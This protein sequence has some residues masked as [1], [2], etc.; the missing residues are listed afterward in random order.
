MSQYKNKGKNSSKKMI[1]EIYTPLHIGSGEELKNNHDFIFKNSRH[2]VVNIKQTLD[3]IQADDPKLNDYYKTT[4]LEDLVKIAGQEYGYSLPSF[5]KNPLL[6]KSSASLSSSK[7]LRSGKRDKPFSIGSDRSADRGNLGIETIREHLKDVF[8]RPFIPGSS[9]KGAIRTAL[10][11][12]SLYQDKQYRA[13]IKNSLNNFLKKTQ[14][15]KFKKNLENDIFGENPQEDIMRSLHISDGY[16]ETDHLRLGDVRTANVCGD[17]IQ[18]KHLSRR[19]NH[20]DWRMAKGTFIEVLGEGAKAE[21]VFSWDEFLLS[22]TSWWQMP[23]GFKNQKH[24]PAK[25]FQ[26]LKTVFNSHALRISSH[27]KA[28]FE[29]YKWPSAVEFYIN[30]EKK[31]KEE[32]DSAWLR[33][34][35]GSG[36]TGM[37]GLTES[38]FLLDEQLKKAIYQVNRKKSEDIYPKTRRLLVQ[39]DSPCLP[40][41][42]VKIY[43]SDGSIQNPYRKSSSILEKHFGLRGRHSFSPW[44]SRQISEIYKECNIKSEEEVLKGRILAQKWKNLSE[45]EEKQKVLKEIIAYW[46][47]RGWWDESASGRNLKKSKQ[48]YKGGVEAN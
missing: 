11:A 19:N 25:N 4:Q 18:W 16:F 36:W 45:G 3:S 28:F 9:I 7:V 37:T 1:L 42:W 21:I 14:K 43:P 31:I 33:V 47:K 23:S 26:D 17:T 6:K 2:F 41:A 46:K 13:R 40:L 30:L 5:S 29:K 24:L 22:E 32:T 44:L 20:K 10:W 15:S 34:G 39:D 27:E 48:I 38:F 8:F 12:E 35:W